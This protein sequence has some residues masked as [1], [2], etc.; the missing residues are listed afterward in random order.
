MAW[1]L[2]V[3]TD[4]RL[5]ASEAFMRAEEFFMYEDKFR[6]RGASDDKG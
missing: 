2:Y 6:R 4:T 5:S 3:E 1:E